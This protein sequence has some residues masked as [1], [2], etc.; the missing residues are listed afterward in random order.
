MSLSFASSNV[1]FISIHALR[2]EGDGAAPHGEQS[3]RNFYPRPPR[4]GRRSCRPTI[5]ASG[6]ISIHA[7]REEGDTEEQHETD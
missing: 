5:K 1:S 3:G 2:E 4:G 7:L 6:R